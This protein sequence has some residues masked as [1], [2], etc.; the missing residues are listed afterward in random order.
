VQ[1]EP[2]ASVVPHVVVKVKS[3]A[4]VPVTV[5]LIEVRVA[6]P[7]FVTVVLRILDE[8]TDTVPNP[9][10]VG[11]MLVDWA[12]PLR[13]TGKVPSSS[14]TFNVADCAPDPVGL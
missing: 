6:V 13:D 4:F 9:R 5:A 7:L 2:A 11:E 8:P 10:L 3:L 12:V 14:L 1:L